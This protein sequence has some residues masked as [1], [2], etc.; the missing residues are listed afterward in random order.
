LHLFTTHGDVESQ[1]AYN[2]SVAELISPSHLQRLREPV[3]NKLA[4]GRFDSYIIKLLGLDEKNTKLPTRTFYSILGDF[5]DEQSVLRQSAYLKKRVILQNL[6]E[7]VEGSEQ[8]TDGEQYT[9]LDSESTSKYVFNLRRDLSNEFTPLLLQRSL[10]F[11]M[12]AKN[13]NIRFL[14]HYVSLQRVNSEVC[15]TVEI[16]GTKLRDYLYDRV[17]TKRK[18]NLLFCCLIEGVL[19]LQE[20]DWVVRSMWPNEIAVRE[21]EGTVIFTNIVYM[22]EEYKEDNFC[23]A[24][25]SPYSPMGM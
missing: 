2:R 20:K 16:T 7:R 3:L 9:I 17:L 13:Q 19:S 14:P 15:L 11:S 21:E 4:E 6:A 12:V 18:G 23:T 10:W 8:L 1:A 5:D 22:C 25:P 24:V